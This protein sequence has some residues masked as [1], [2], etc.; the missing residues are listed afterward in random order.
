MA[1]DETGAFGRILAAL[2]SGATLL[3]P[4][5]RSARFWSRHYDAAV[6]GRGGKSWLAPR[7]LP[8]SAW[9]SS[10]WQAA[11]VRGADLRILLNDVQE[12]SLWRTVIQ[13]S[14]SS[15]L[16]SPESQAELCVAANR[17]LGSYDVEA[18]FAQGRYGKDVRSPD[19]NTFARWYV[20]FARICGSEGYLPASQLELELAALL[21]TQRITGDGDYLLCG[22]PSLTPARQTL[23]TALEE[24]DG[25]VQ[26]IHPA[27]QAQSAPGLL[28]CSDTQVEMQQCALWIRQQVEASPE[29][30]VTVVVPDLQAARPELE[31]ELRTVVAPDAADVTRPAATVIYEF[32]SGRPLR[33]LPMVRDALRLLH[34]C[35]QD[36]SM[37]EAGAILRSR[38]LTV[39][40]SPEAGTALDLQVLRELPALQRTVSLAQA[41]A[42]FVRHNAADSLLLLERK[43]RVCRGAENTYAWFADNARD[44][45]ASAGFPGTEGLSSEEF[46]AADRWNEMLDRLATLDLLGQRTDFPTFLTELETLA[47]ET[48]FAPENRGVPVQVISVAEA[49]GSTSDALWFL[50][51]DSSTWPSRATP[52]P[53]LPW[54]LQH[55]LQMPGTDLHRD[56]QAA[57]LTLEH[58]VRSSGAVTFSYSCASQEDAQR[59]S[60]LIEQT[61]HALGGIETE[62]EPPLE[63]A[64]PSDLVAT[65]LDET[66]VPL[67]TDGHVAGGIGVLTAQAQCGFRAF[68]EKR[69]F[70]K[71]LEHL[72]AGL[73][74][75]D[76]G[77]QVHTVL[78]N[79]WKV[80]QSQQRLAE[81]SRK[82]NTDGSSERDSLL[83]SCIEQAVRPTSGETWDAAYLQVQRQRL[84]K[85]VSDWLDF[86]LTRPPFEVL[87]T[88]KEIQDV[89]IGPLKLAMRVDRVDRVHA[90]EEEEGTL[91]IDYKT[92]AASAREWLGERPDQP[93]LPAYA[94]AGALA[95]GIEQVDGLAFGSV[96][97]G[98]AGMRLEGMAAAPA[99]LGAKP[100]NGLD[101]ADQVEAWREDLERLAVAFAEGDASVDPKQY[102][103]TC[104]RCSQRMLCRVDA[105]ALLQLEELEREEEEDGAAAWN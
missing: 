29:S 63:D 18:R 99:L 91:L 78:E 35:A 87:H 44:L 45:L 34:W 33:H 21:R 4:N 53:L 10:L 19:A 49:S 46:Q 100:R 64:T 95:A 8:W 105:A 71:P 61:V 70:A 101:F 24:A 62:A 38:H 9:T 81:I 55:E 28:R 97:V 77:E 7:I 65:E 80:V 36:L 102:P 90:S 23:L 27:V 83:R 20:A 69:L 89:P 5:V 104:D 16:Q 40:A 72:D 17:L 42:A 76:R 96:K 67:T 43:A 31:R 51:A 60:P 73:S 92:G 13:A 22:F 88:E 37:D 52:H 54:H 14:S 48:L 94:V 12:R 103:K 3:T 2:E 32:S 75:G 84:F 56:E 57:H 82:R 86:E 15:T 66:T 11:V 50:H 41:A 59:P 26:F 93:Q 68:A 74:P 47:Q 79:F 30:S 39:A 85:L 25:S 58:L 1:G 98:A 6:R